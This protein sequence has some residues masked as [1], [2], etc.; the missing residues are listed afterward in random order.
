[1]ERE[2]RLSY[3]ALRELLRLFFVP[4]FLFRRHRHGAVAGCFYA[5]GN[6]PGSFA[7][8]TAIR[9]ASPGVSNS[10]LPK[11]AGFQFLDSPRRREAASGYLMSK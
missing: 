8:F 3:L 2:A 6:S 11:V 7:I 1:L 9:R 4:G 10:R 5:F